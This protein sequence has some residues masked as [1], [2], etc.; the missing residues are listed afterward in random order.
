M[1]NMAKADR[2]KSAIAILPLRPLRESGN[3][4]QT[5]FRPQR[6]DPKIFIPSVNYVSADLGIPALK[7]FA[8]RSFRT[9]VR[10]GLQRTPKAV[11]RPRAKRVEWAPACDGRKPGGG[12]KRTTGAREEKRTANSISANS[13]NIRANSEYVRAISE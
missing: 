13:E 6:S 2:P 4:A 7:N 10:R 12:G 1:K 8:L 9:A 3:A 5:A 11:F